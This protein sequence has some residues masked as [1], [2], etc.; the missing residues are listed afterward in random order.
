MDLIRKGI[1]KGLD[2]SICL[3]NYKADGTPFWNQLFIAAL[4]NT[5]GRIVNFV[6]VQCEVKRHLKLQ[7]ISIQLHVLSRAFCAGEQTC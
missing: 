6:G 3:L 2:I 1:E 4:R 5:D 7:D